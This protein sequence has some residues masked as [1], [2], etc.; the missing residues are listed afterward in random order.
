MKKILLL[1]LCVCSSVYAESRV[2][3]PVVDN[4]I[5]P[6]GSGAATPSANAMFEVLGRLEQLQLEVQQLRG[7]VEEQS[8]TIDNLKKRQG[9]IYSDLDLRLQEVTGVKTVSKEIDVDGGNFHPVAPLTA[10][11]P[12]TAEPV[13]EIAGSQQTAESGFSKAVTEVNLPAVSDKERYQSAY[14]MLRN[15]HN[16]R[17]IFGFKALLTESPAG[18]YADNSQYWLG[19]AYKVNRKIEA[20][21]QAFL[22]VVNDYSDSPKVPDAL[23]KLGYIEFEQN[24][25]AKARDYLTQ[26]TVSHP[27]TTAAHLAAKKLTQMG[28]MQF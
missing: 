20:A 5:Y 11:M 13:E 12:T 3:P 1:M 6:S 26:V 16:S 21:K 28:S 15:G 2:L 24:N 19:E 9:N 7:V 10:V 25:M 17:A 23:L 4:S 22:R 8:Q 18:E 14:E 27:N